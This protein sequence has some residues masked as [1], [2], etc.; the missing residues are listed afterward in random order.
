MHKTIFP[1]ADPTDLITYLRA[2]ESSTSL[3][4]NDAVDLR[5][6]PQ[7]TAFVEC[8][9]RHRNG[10]NAPTYR[11]VGYVPVQTSDFA[12]PGSV[13]VIWLNAFSTSPSAS[14]WLGLPLNYEDAELLVVPLPNYPAPLMPVTIPGAYPG[15]VNF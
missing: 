4:E 9:I 8:A 12:R 10:P 2:E 11:H 5:D 7:G 3:F 1:A 14:N 15:I 13:V 6:V